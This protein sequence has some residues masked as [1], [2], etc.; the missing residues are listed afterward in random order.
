MSKTGFYFDLSVLK[1]Q[2]VVIDYENNKIGFSRNYSVGFEE[3]KS[4]NNKNEDKNFTKNNMQSLF[5]LLTVGI[6]FIFLVCMINCA[7]FIITV[8][9]TKR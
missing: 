2:I 7:I 8:F 4:Q 6:T 5:L 3:E 1:K 9:V